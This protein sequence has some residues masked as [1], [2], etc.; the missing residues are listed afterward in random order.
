MAMFD[1]H[2][3]SSDAPRRLRCLVEGETYTFPVTIP[4]NE[5]ITD[6][7]TRI[8]E[9]GSFRGILAKDLVLLK[10]SYIL[11]KFSMNITAHFSVFCQVDVDLESYCGTFREL[12]F[13]KSDEGVERLKEWETVSSFW[14]DQSSDRPPKLRVFVKLPSYSE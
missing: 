5:L 3:L 6:L 9:K 1:T 8:H 7:K 11:L 4:G 12:T 10:V 13:K 2:G 14:P